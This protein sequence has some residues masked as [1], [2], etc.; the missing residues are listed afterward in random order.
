MCMKNK[1]AM[2]LK[3]LQVRRSQT[4]N[5]LWSPDFYSHLKQAEHMLLQRERS[6]GMFYATMSKLLRGQTSVARNKQKC[7]KFKYL[8][9]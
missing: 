1:T 8:K 5:I 9:K 2:Q 7:I 4:F 3:F 6:A